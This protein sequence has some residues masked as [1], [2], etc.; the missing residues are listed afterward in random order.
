M[1]TS[2]Q[3][4]A[5]TGHEAFATVSVTCVLDDRAHEVPD[6]ELAAGL[7]GCSGRYQALCGHMIAAAPLVMPDGRPC[8]HCAA[9]REPARRPRVGLLRRLIG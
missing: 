5:V 7:A 6:T 3:L 9:L 1:T 2:R 4:P 8:R